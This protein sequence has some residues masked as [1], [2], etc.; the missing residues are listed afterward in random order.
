MSTSTNS[1]ENV[2]L[3]NMHFFFWKKLQ[4][5]IHFF[6][7]KVANNLLV[8]FSVNKTIYT[9]RAMCYKCYNE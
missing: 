1:Q 4:T 2:L 5:F 9:Y 6:V 8:Q 7:N 3:L